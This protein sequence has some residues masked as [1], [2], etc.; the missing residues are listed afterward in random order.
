MKISTKGRY[1]LRMMID[2]A[3]NQESGS[4]SLKD[5]SKRQDISLKYLEQIVGLLTRAGFLKS[6]RGAGGGYVLTKTP[7]KYTVGD[8]LRVTEGNLAPVAC[9]EEKDNLCPKAESCKA[10]KY[11]QGLYDVINNYLDG[12][13]LLDLT[14]DKWNGDNVG[15][16]I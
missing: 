6:R 14:E 15:A 12:T 13:T 11:W 4:V 2:I 7:D 16:F 9:L 8:I 3:E 5:I 1:A 10:V